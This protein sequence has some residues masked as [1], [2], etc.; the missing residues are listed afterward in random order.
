[1]KLDPDILTII[2]L[3]RLVGKADT[4]ECYSKDPDVKRQADLDIRR[5][6]AG[7]DEAAQRL[8]KRLKK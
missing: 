6:E 3:S 8:Q 2:Q 4:H 5:Y 1:M 7:I